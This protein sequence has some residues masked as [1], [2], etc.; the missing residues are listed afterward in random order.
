MNTIGKKLYLRIYTN[1]TEER[2]KVI[3]AVQDNN[4]KTAS[5]DLYSFH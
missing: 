5:D 1:G 2:K 3:E 4:F